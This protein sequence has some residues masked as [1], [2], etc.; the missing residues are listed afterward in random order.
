MWALYLWTHFHCT[1][2]INWCHV[3]RVIDALGADELREDVMQYYNDSITL[4]G[5]LEKCYWN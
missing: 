3:S 5:G 4:K 1:V 2:L